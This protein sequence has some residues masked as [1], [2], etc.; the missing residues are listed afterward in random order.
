M[1]Q[2]KLLKIS[3]D[4][5]PLEF[6]EST[7]EITLLSYTVDGG[8]PV[9]S[10]TGLDLNN[11][12][13]SDVKNLDFNNPATATIDQT[14]GALIVD[15]LMFQ[16][17]N[18]IMTTAGAV[19]FPV[20]TD[21]GA[22]VDAFRVPALAGVPTATPTSGGEGFMVWDSTNNNMY[23]WDGSAWNN[24]NTVD[25][26]E[27]VVNMYTADEALSARDVLYISA[28][29]NVSKADVSGSGVASRVVGFARA[30]AADTASVEVQ[31]EGV[32]AGF[33]GLSTTARYYADPATPGGI[34]TTTPVGAGNTIVQ[35][36]YAKSTTALHLHI[37]QLGRRS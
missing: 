25:Q 12:D 8:G 36:G 5:V 32:L 19:L 33:T 6:T 21:T 2:V 35:V 28:A 23:V 17:K 4:G 3:S 7:D 26:A 13:V 11:Q 27:R 18:N 10:A 14:A 31:S 16:T 29:D 34:T 15:D 20:I 37:E 1:A 24:Q 30:A 22:Q 9:L